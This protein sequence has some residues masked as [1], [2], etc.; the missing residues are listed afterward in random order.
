LRSIVIFHP[1][2]FANKIVDVASSKPQSCHPI[3]N[4]VTAR[5]T[6]GNDGWDAHSCS[7]P[8]CERLCFVPKRREDQRSRLSQSLDD[9]CP[10][11]PSRDFCLWTQNLDIA[12][13]IPF[14][15]EHGLKRSTGGCFSKADRTFF[16]AKPTDHGIS[17]I[18][19][20]VNE[21]L[22]RYVNDIG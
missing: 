6:V 12:S 8:N 19:H 17:R 20:Y 21:R 11:T 22:K 2:D 16:T 18:G 1:A 14:P 5:T 3:D 7:F 15:H 13:T 9:L 4:I 10:R